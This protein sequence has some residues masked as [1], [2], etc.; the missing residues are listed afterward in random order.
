MHGL[1]PEERDRYEKDG[2][3]ARE[4][5]F[6]EAELA[7]LRD[8]AEGVHAQILE[9]AGADLGGPIEQIDNQKFQEVKGSTIKWEW[10]DDLRAIRSMEPTHHLDRRLE[11]LM[12]DPRLWGPCADIIGTRS[13]S[14][15]SD[16]LNVKRPGGAPFPWHQEGPYWAYGAEDLERVVTLILYL[17]DATEENGCL[18]VIPGTHRYGALEALKDRGTLGRL[19]TDVERLDEK[20]WPAALP[21]GSVLWFHRD[22]VHGSQTNRTAENRRAFLLAYQPAGLRQWRNSERRDIRTGG[23]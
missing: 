21:A 20:P 18:W 19:Y 8:A 14:L 1:T 17:D 7:E 11:R 5:I 13:L 23:A 10:R 9:A 15:F 4:R 12:D 2:F 6:S 16:K 3:F 22:T